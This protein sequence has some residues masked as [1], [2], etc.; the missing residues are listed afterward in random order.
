M[1]KVMGDSL[2]FVKETP[3]LLELCQSTLIYELQEVL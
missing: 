3:S 2:L 1:H